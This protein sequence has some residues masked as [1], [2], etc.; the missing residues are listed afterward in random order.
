MVHQFLFSYFFV[1]L[2]NFNG[3]IEVQFTHHKSH[4]FEVYGSMSF[5]KFIQLCHHLLRQ[6]D[7]ERDT[8]SV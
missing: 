8:L 2:K 1:F 5:H 4:L 7:L 6:V 3:F